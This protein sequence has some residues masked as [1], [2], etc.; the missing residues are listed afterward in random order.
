MAD[1]RPAGSIGC[2]SVQLLGDATLSEMFGLHWTPAINA[3]AED[4]HVDRGH[5]RRGILSD[6]PARP[7]V[8]P[9]RRL[10]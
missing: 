9:P 1:S 2:I 5:L 6:E 8:S 7:W 3:L 10:T 4:L